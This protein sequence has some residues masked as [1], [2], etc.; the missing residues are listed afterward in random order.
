MAEDLERETGFCSTELRLWL[1]DQAPTVERLPEMMSH[2]GVE[3][4]LVEALA[5]RIEVVAKKLQE[6]RP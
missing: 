5:G 6:A 1:S 4:A 3:E 2:C